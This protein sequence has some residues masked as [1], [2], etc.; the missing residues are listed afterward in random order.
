MA[1]GWMTY[2]EELLAEKAHEDMLLDRLA[3]G[4]P[5]PPLDMR[6]AKRIKRIKRKREINN[7][8]K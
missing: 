6:E 1:N 2:E 4:L 7:R 5:M 3:K 8:E